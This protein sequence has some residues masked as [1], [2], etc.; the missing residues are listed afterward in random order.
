V[1]SVDMM[2]INKEGKPMESKDVQ[3][4]EKEAEKS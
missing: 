1:D 2:M 4:V 3:R